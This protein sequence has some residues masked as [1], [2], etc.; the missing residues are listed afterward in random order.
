MALA[1]TY[2]QQE[3]IS[4]FCLSPPDVTHPQIVGLREC[5]LTDESLV[6]AMEYV[7]GCNM[8]KWVTSQCA[9]QR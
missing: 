6:I 9:R 8:Y 3:V 1:K 4:H 7:K 5:F 2:V